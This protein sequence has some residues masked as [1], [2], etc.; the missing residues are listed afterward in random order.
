MKPILIFSKDVD[1]T[2][3][4]CAIRKCSVDLLPFSG[5]HAV[6]SL[7][8]EGEEYPEDRSI[9]M[10]YQHTG[11]CDMFGLDRCHAVQNCVA[12]TKS[13]WL[14]PKCR[15]WPFEYM[16]CS[17]DDHNQKHI[18]MAGSERTRRSKYPL[19]SPL[20]MSSSLKSRPGGLPVQR[21]VGSAPAS[22]LILPS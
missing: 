18:E 14:P 6:S 1:D 20:S 5:R 16:S 4:K 2:I 15:R 8:T 9:T 7:E 17:L 12:W 13:T 21:N 19:N 10:A 11:I 3:I 22:I